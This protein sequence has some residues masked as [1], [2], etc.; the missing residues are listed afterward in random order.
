MDEKSEEKR[1]AAAAAVQL[2][3]SGMRVG[4]GTGSTVAIFLKLLGER[5]RAGLKI[6][7][8]ASSLKTERE[9]N[10]YGIPL[11]SELTATEL[12][13]TVD[14]AD[15]IDQHKNLIKGGGGALLREKIVASM[16]KEL[17]I[18]ADQS[19][20]V[21]T[22]AHARLPVEI[23]PFGFTSILEHIAKLNVT[24]AMRFK[25]GENSLYTTDN[26]NHIADILLPR[27]MQDYTEFDRALHYIP[28]VLE[29]GFFFHLADRVIYG[30]ADGSVNLN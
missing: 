19:K 2:I 27:N 4:L 3:E 5:C 23:L 26:G 25:K 13:I 28:G 20:L 7:A 10:S 24:A 29:T 15:M 1:A 12:D 14:G 17:V 22:F 6:E 18:I 21:D 30:N 9:A 16:S 8:L 11:M